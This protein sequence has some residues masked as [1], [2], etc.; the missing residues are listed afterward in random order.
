M[1]LVDVI[2]TPD[3]T[4]QVR[5][6]LRAD[7]WN[8]RRHTNF[9]K[10]C[11]LQITAPQ[12]VIQDL[13]LFVIRFIYG[14]T[15]SKTPGEARAAKW[16]TEKKKRTIQLPPD[17]DSLQQHLICTNY[18]AFL[19]RHY[20]LKR[21]LSPIDHRWTLSTCPV[22]SATTSL[23]ACCLYLNLQPLSYFSILY[24]VPTAFYFILL[25]W[26]CCYQLVSLV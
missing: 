11:G 17:S 4:G 15:K 23:C 5:S 22:D 6:W 1:S 18:P 10:K 16:R 8:Q 19:L 13:K 12:K 26:L 7:S 3:S 14:D 24:N 20:Q 21:H 9:D 25:N 2:T